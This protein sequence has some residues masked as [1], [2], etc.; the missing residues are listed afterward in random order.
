MFLIIDGN[1]LAY[2]C[3]FITS[4]KAIANLKTEEE[5]QFY[6]EYLKKSPNGDYVGAIESFVSYL[7]DFIEDTSLN[8][9][10]IAI[11]FDESRL[12]TFRKKQYPAYKEQRGQ[13]PEPLL[14]QM[15]LLKKILKECGI[16]VYEHPL[17]E[18]DD[19]AGSIATHFANEENICI[20]TKDK[21][22][23][24]LIN[25]KVHIW[26]MKDRNDVGRLSDTYGRNLCIRDNIFEYTSEVVK[27]EY[28]ITPKQVIAWKA[29]S[30]DPSDNIPGVKGVSDKTIIPLL[31]QYGSLLEL[32][33][34]MQRYKRNE[35]LD[36]LAKKWKD[37]LNI[38]PSSVEKLW[39]GRLDAAFFFKLV[40]IKTNIPVLINKDD[41]NVKNIDFNK[42]K[43]VMIEIGLDD[44]ADDI[45]MHFQLNKDDERCFTNRV[46]KDNER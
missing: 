37:E 3:F 44:V 9:K 1:S 31:N 16:K 26:M 2:T 28:G 36:F 32:Y 27:G 6:Y 41:F 30:G 8:I 13:K 11:C 4:P 39:D 15:A 42:L 22:Y 29:I 17:Y 21:D 24:Q 7:L 23:L 20:L 33:K 45:S 35:R 43:D 5:R 34:E 46:S 19:I 40:T 14:E 38:K 18:A 25:D 12:S 10:E